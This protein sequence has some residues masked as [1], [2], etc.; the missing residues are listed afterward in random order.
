M[1]AV[2]QDAAFM[3]AIGAVLQHEGGY[4]A[5]P[6]DRGNWASGMIGVGDLRGTNFGISAMSYPTLDIINLTREQAIGIY[7]SDWWIGRGIGTLPSPFGPKVLDIAVN[8]GTKP[9]EAC[10][11]QA[12][13]QCGRPVA[14]D[15]VIGTNSLAAIAAVDPAVL[16]T[17]FRLQLE[18]HYRQIVIAHPE[19]ARFL[20]GWLARADA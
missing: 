6:A 18:Q 16:M 13:A 5:N 20:K 11:Q 1:D 15:G 12:L 10:L 14:V 4:T 3:A 8:T 19:D 2:T 7:Y 17:A 9:A